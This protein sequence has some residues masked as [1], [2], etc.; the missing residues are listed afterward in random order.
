MAELYYYS[1]EKVDLNDIQKCAT[2]INITGQFS[3][4]SGQETLYFEELLDGELTWICEFLIADKPFGDVHESFKTEH[5]AASTIQFEFNYSNVHNLRKLLSQI[6]QVHDGWFID[7]IA[8]NFVDSSKGK[9]FYY[10]KGN[11]EKFGA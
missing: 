6:M 5:K 10:F 2:L 3:V 8:P 7:D 4:R 9:F 1:M 11:I